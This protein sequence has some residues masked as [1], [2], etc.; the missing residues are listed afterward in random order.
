PDHTTTHQNPSSNDDIWDTLCPA[1]GL[2]PSSPQ[3]LAYDAAISALTTTGIPVGACSPGGAIP[4]TAPFPPTQNQLQPSS[5]N[6]ADAGGVGSQATP[7]SPAA[8]ARGQ[9]PLSDMFVPDN[10]LLYMAEDLPVFGIWGD[11]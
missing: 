2:D 5:A 8:A 6:A 9:T 4:S 1:P 11:E 7:T 3:A 10:G